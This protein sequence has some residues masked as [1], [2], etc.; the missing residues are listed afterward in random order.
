M[1]PERVRYDTVLFDIGETLVGPRTGFGAVYAGVLAELG[2]ESTP[3]ELGRSLRATVATMTRELPPG[4]D[5]YREVH[6]DERGFWRAVVAGTLDAVTGSRVEPSTVDAALERLRAAFADPAAW[7]VYDDV[8]PMLGRL[9]EAGVRLG[10][11]SNWDSRL[12]ALLER[13]DLSRWFDA[14]AVSHLEGVEKPSPR[15]FEIAL[16][17][18]GAGPAG[19][20]HVGNVPAFDLIGGHAAGLDVLL[21]DRGSGEAADHE[22]LTDLA[23]LP[24][25]VDGSADAALAA[26]VSSP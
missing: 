10:V 17:R 25:I 6:G 22:P 16:E 20:L 26:R 24:A 2:I 12:P 4:S 5:R 19:T 14:V 21:V 15:L 18:L 13:L 8:R 11:V 1:P 23:V 7:H 9:T 3:A